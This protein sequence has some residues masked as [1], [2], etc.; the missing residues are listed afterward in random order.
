MNK[1][2]VVFA[3]TVIKRSTRSRTAKD[4]IRCALRMLVLRLWRRSVVQKPR[5][6]QLHILLDFHRRPIST[7]GSGGGAKA[8]RLRLKIP[9]FQILIHD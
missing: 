9:M 5:Y 8:A 6:V 2:F 7:N 3:L 1:L 4:L